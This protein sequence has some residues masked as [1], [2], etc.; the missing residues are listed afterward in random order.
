MMPFINKYNWKEI[1]LPSEKDD[2]KKLEK[3]NVSIAL[4]VLYTKIEKHT[5]L[6]FQ[7]ITQILKNKLLF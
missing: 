6:M 3:N 5:L 2:W 1:N 4:N 7:N